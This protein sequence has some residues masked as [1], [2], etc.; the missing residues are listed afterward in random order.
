MYRYLYVWVGPMKNKTSE[1]SKK[2]IL[3]IV[4]KGRKPTIIYSNAGS[5]FIGEFQ[6]FLKDQKII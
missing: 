5:E 4:A 6:E 2:A 3:G 1:E